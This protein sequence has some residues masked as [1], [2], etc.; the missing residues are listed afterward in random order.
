MLR[1]VSTFSSKYGKN[2]GSY[3]SIPS[4]NKI[5]THQKTFLLSQ[6]PAENDEFSV[7]SYS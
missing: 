6:A 5:F 1:L 3:Y 4:C 2:I 7:S